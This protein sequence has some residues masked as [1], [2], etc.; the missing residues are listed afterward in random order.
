MVGHSLNELVTKQPDW[1]M[2]TKTPMMVQLV[3]A[4]RRMYLRLKR[5]VNILSM[6]H[7]K[8]GINFLKMVDKATL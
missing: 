8:S 6:I 5:I 3:P 1:K 7:H 4:T 2:R